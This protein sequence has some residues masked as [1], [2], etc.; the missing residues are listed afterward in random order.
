MI[1]Q[2]WGATKTVTGSLH[3]VQVDGKRFV[4]DCGLYQGHRDEAESINRNI[5]VEHPEDLDFLFL[6]HAHID[7]S[8]NIPTLVKSGFR[9]KIVTTKATADLISVMLKDSAYIQEKDVEYVNRKRKRKGL[10]PKEPL[11]SKKDVES[12]LEHLEPID[13]N[14]WFTIGNEARVIF[15]D[16]G[17]ILGSAVILIEARENGKMKRLLFTGDL[18][19]EGMPIIRDP[20]QVT[21]VHF[22]ITESTYGGRYHRPYHE[23]NS[24][25][26]R[27]IQ[28]AYSRR[29]KII[30]PAFSV[31][32][33]QEIV[34]EIQQLHEAGELPDIPIFVD[35]PLSVNVTGIFRRHPECFD[36]EALEIIRN[37]DDPF[38]FEQL[39]YIKDVEESK[40]LN[41]I[42]EPCI[43]I[44]ASGMCEA[45]RILHHLKNSIEDGRNMVLIVGYQAAGTLGRNL[46]KKKRVVRIFGEEYTRRAEISIL[47]E[48]SSHGDRKDLIS[49]ASNSGAQKIFC[50]HGD[51]EQIDEFAKGL[52]EAKVGEIHIPERGAFFEL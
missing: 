52:K 47:N 11:Y 10:P 21:D 6:S 16:A 40:R 36:E 8:G 19:R 17:H 9:G 49:Y 15:F 4:L 22:L 13:Y 27:I 32:R 38:G 46:V 31:G 34:Y 20:V 39:K 2:F 26:K 28:R 30:I 23:V 51:E 48:F 1:V 44:S 14:A 7:H 33:T 24:E 42:D 25:L 3:Y 5:P 45:G 37:H 50:V 29:G 18:G 43:I 41:R 35:S 12:A